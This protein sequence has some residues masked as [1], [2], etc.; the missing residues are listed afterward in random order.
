MSF[1]T[2]R[3]RAAQAGESFERPDRARVLVGSAT[4]GRAA[5][6]LEVLA[7]IRRALTKHG[8]EETT[9]VVEVGCLGPCYAEPLV[10]VRAADGQR[11]LYHN[12]TPDL[13]N[14]LVASHLGAGKPVLDKAI[15]VMDGSMDG[16][17]AFSELP[18][19]K[20]QVRVVLRNCGHM[21]PDNLDHSIARGG[22]S[23]LVH[24]LSMKPEEVIAEVEASGLRGRAGAGFP[25]GRKWRLARNA[26]GATKYVICNADEGDP[27]AFMNRSVLEG[28]PHAVLEGL[29]SSGYAIGAQLG[30]VYVRAEY[31]LAVARLNTAL[32]AMRENG[33][34]G[35]D[36]LGSGFDF[37]IHIKMGAGAFVCG[38]ETALMASIEGRRGMPR[39]RPPFPAVSGLFGKSTTI[40]NVETLASVSAIVEKGAAWFAAWGTD[41]SK[42]TKTFAL[43]GKINRPGL[44]EVSMGTTLRVIIEEVGGGIPDG[45]KFK[46]VQTGGPS[47]GCIPAERM[48]LPVDYEKL[49]EAGSIMGSGGMVVL[50][51]ESCM[52][53]V[54]KYFLAFTAD[55]SCGKCTPCR[56]GTRRML[57]ILERICAGQGRPGDIDLLL[58]LGPAIK[59]TSFVRPRPDGAQSR[60]H[61]H[62]LF[63][64]RVRG[65]HPGSPLPG[66]GLLGHG[67]RALHSYLSRRSRSAPIRA[68]D[69]ERELRERVPGRARANA[70][71]FRMRR[72]L[73]PPVRAALPARAAG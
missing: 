64:R 54:A 72:D 8:L 1:D 30:Y 24:A 59:C 41:K 10:E 68:R 52:V 71:P 18:M 49:A 35:R 55:E 34:L 19:I 23:G 29:L 36:I 16:V 51:E 65:A 12:V 2:L 42:D 15:A 25:T 6:A 46:A 44:I 62:S 39:P 63:P 45:K 57:T 43:T 50:D 28:D 61:H 7:A 17:P 38:E 21:D 56:L 69:R 70:A 37:E 27:G 9:D 60:A 26:P 40:N 31:P 53:D 22:Y 66:R 33:L 58:E 11:V 48:D 32:R 47:G 20:H 14:T 4:C 5:G 3:Q 67:G 73:L 13:A